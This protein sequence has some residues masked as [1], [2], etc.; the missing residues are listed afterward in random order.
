M[1]FKSGRN[2]KATNPINS[3]NPKQGKNKTTKPQ[4]PSRSNFKIHKIE[5]KFNKEKI[6]KVAKGKKKTLHR[7]CVCFLWMP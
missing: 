1:F 3:L 5:A 4:G 7:G 6:L 2:G